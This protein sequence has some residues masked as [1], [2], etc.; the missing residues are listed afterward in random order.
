MDTEM[1]TVF[2]ACSDNFIYI[3]YDNDNIYIL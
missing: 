2:K 1:G 3:D